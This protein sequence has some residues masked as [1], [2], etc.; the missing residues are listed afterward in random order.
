MLGLPFSHTLLWLYVL[1]PGVLAWLVTRPVLEGKRLPELVL[2]S[3]GTW[4]S[5]APGAGWRRWRRRTRSW[6][7]ARVWRRPRPG[8]D[9]DGHRRP[10]GSRGPGAGR[11]GRAGLASGPR[12]RRCRASWAPRPAGA[13]PGRARPAAGRGGRR[14][15]RGG[16]CGRYGAARLA[17]GPG[18][19][20]RRQPGT[21]PPVTPARGPAGN[22]AARRRPGTGRAHPPA[23][24]PAQPLPARSP[25]P[26]G[27]GAR[28]AGR[29][30]VTAAGW[31]PG[32]QPPAID[33]SRR[34]GRDGQDG[35]TG[36]E[37][38]GR[39]AAAAARPGGR[40]GSRRGTGQAAPGRPL[41]RGGRAVGGQ[42]LP[43]SNVKVCLVAGV[44]ASAGA[45]Y[46]RRAA[47]SSYPQP[48]RPAGRS[49]P[50]ARASARGAA[51][52]PRRLRRPVPGGRRAPGWAVRDRPSRITRP[53]RARLRRAF[54]VRLPVAMSSGPAGAS[55][56]PA[57]S[58]PAGLAQADA[59]SA[60]RSRG[61]GR[62]HPGRCGPA[63]RVRSRPAM[64]LAA[65]LPQLRGG[66]SFPAPA[67]RWAP[68]PP[69]RP[70]RRRAHPAAEPPPSSRR[71]SG[72]PAARRS[73]AR[74]AS[75]R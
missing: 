47:G 57:R 72:S 38:D 36:R 26:D 31:P 39:D 62:R 4:A 21:R 42:Q 50:V 60:R 44:G 16:G 58:R 5:R 53:G 61:A 65:V 41:A 17:G 30:G 59:R 1:P 49:A 11:P 33:R 73:R 23:G 45:A 74:R 67:S 15:C 56:V 34:G 24:T 64:R 54:T 6:S 40:T 43:H 2:P 29:R 32:P 28:A 27:A 75:R 10:F 68:R 48:P 52:P 8:R 25:R 14:R 19:A 13:A 3:C 71:R 63:R 12:A 46:A 69:V 9:G 37:F 66:G 55:R 18:A 22:V 51:R 7:F 20:P 70:P 35:A